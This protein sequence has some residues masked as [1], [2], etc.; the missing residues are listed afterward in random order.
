[1]SCV[2]WPTSAE[3]PCGVLARRVARNLEIWVNLVPTRPSSGGKLGRRVADNLGHMPPAFYTRLGPQDYRPSISVQGAWRDDE[4]HMAPLSGLITEALIRHEPRE[5]MRIA[6][7]SF[8]IL[9]L[10]PLAD[11]HIEVRT[12]RPGRTIEL[13]E[14]NATVAGRT[15]VTA[16]AWR[17]ILTD[18]SDVAGHELATMPAPQDCAD[19]EAGGSEWPGGFIASLQWRM[20]PGGREGRRGVWVRSTADLLDDEPVDPISSFVMLVDTAN[21]SATRARPTDL[22]YPNVDLGI[23]LLRAPDPRWVGLDV[24]ASFGADGIGLTSSTLSDITGP[25]G[26]AEQILTVR[27]FPG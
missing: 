19:Y 20:A 16:R 24:A 26:R 12:I 7:L 27:H 21:G 25:V 3:R 6:R 13:L 17:L 23:H 5:G 22:M 2:P 9:G 18:T 10:I 15:V 4:Q 1:M 8:E 11:T 14:A